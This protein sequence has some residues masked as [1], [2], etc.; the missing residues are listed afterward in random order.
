[1]PMYTIIGSNSNTSINR[2]VANKIDE[3]LNLNIIE[4]KEDVIPIYSPQREV[5]GIPDEINRIYE[6]LKSDTKLIIFTPEYNG[7]TT[8][9]FKNIFDWLSRIEHSFLQDIDV[10]IVTVTPGSLGGASVRKILSESLPYFGAKSVETYGL[11]DFYKK[12][13]GDNLTEDL[14]NIY[15]IISN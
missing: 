11:G 13:E 7:Y 3:R 10:K 5:E 15:S 4:V 9:Y 6:I 2:E 8:P 12:V 14:D 1:M